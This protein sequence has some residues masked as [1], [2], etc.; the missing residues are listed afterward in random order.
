MKEMGI[1]ERASRIHGSGVAAYGSIDGECVCVCAR[2]NL[3]YA[4]TI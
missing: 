1:A 2:T 4:E 3:R